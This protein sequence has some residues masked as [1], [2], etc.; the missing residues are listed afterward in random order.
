M[1]Q[2]GNLALSIP[3]NSF[4]FSPCF[5]HSLRLR[6]SRCPSLTIYLA[7]LYLLRL[8]SCTRYYSVFFLQKNYSQ[9]KGEENKNPFPF[10]YSCYNQLHHLKAVIPGSSIMD[11]SAFTFLT[12]L[13]LVPAGTG[14]GECTVRCY[15]L[16]Q[17]KLP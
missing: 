6:I 15:T 9:N 5:A 3:R 13:E 17:P 11:L 8:A 2:G 10:S 12:S 7:L 14:F 16:S 4:R 1:L